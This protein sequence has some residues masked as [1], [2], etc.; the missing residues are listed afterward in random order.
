V[1]GAYR[2]LLRFQ[3][4]AAGRLEYP[5]LLGSTGDARR[6]AALLETLLNVRIDVA[7]P[8]DIAQQPLTMIILPLGQGGPSC[9]TEAEGGRR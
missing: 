5:Q 2:S 4:D 7:P 1:P 9:D 8:T 3:I 6:D